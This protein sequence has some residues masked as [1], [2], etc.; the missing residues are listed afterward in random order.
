MVNFVIAVAVV[1]V[2]VIFFS[3]PRKVEPIRLPVKI[4]KSRHIKS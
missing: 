2:G 4:T 3:T 1:V